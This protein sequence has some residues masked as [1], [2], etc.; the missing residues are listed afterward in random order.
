MFLGDLRDDHNAEFAQHFY[1]AL[2]VVCD[3]LFFSRYR[4][5]SHLTQTLADNEGVD[6]TT[7]ANDLLK[8]SMLFVPLMKTK[9]KVMGGIYKSR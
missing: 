2:S 3:D 8:V 6:I 4:R 7:A 1:R 9:R 5:E